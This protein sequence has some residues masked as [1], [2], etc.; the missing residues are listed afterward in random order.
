MIS[1]RGTSSSVL[2]PL[3]SSRIQGCP[4]IDWRQK[5]EENKG[6]HQKTGSAEL[7]AETSKNM[8]DTFEDLARPPAS[9]SNIGAVSD[10]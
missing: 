8:G 1:S 5:Q 6:L 10:D 7:S 4:A 2:P 9:Q 3:N